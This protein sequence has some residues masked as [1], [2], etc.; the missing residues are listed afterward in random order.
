MMISVYITDMRTGDFLDH[1]PDHRLDEWDGVERIFR[2]STKLFEGYGGMNC[3]G[4]GYDRAHSYW[5]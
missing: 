4:R 5:P 2:Q 3:N 1:I